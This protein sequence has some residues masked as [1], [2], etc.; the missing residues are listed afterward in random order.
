MHAAE[1]RGFERCEWVRAVRQGAVERL[2]AAFEF[3]V[4]Q[5]VE[6][7]CDIGVRALTDRG[8]E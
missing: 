3:E 2:V 6:F 4:Q 7:R 5:S 8:D 1:Q